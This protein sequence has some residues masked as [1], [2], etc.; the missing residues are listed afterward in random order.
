[1]SKGSNT[2]KFIIQEKAWNTMQQYAKI[3]HK[4]DGNEIS[5]LMPYKMIK[6]PVSDENVYE[7]FDPVILK[8]E[9]TGATTE[10]DGEAIRDYQIKAGMKYG[11]D[12]KFCWWHSHHTM[13]AFWSGTD[14]NEINA[15]ENDSWSLALVV[16][17]FQEYKLNVSVWHPVK[18]SE[19][20]R[21]E[22]IRSMPKETKKQLKEYEELCSNKTSIASS[23]P[24]WQKVGYG[25]QTSM[26]KKYTPQTDDLLKG[27]EL[28]WVDG[29]SIVP[30]AELIECV[31]EAV[32]TMIE[33]FCEGKIDYDQYSKT[34]DT[35]NE[36]LKKKNAKISIIKL[37]KGSVLEKSMTMQTWEHIKYQTDK[38]E[39]IYDSARV[40]Q[41]NS[42][43][44]VG[45]EWLC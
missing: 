29:E 32:E 44:G 15:W 4:E 23:M 13:D 27:T 16:N 17:L 37:T 12:I 28:K 35:M 34:I 40:T 25:S 30:Y 7:L 1:M 8:Q 45:G 36:Q 5:G 6:H 43:Y 22:I 33:E 24:G 14:K 38:I 26:W 3:A 39:K 19:D 31:D 21:L 10:L 41:Y 42:S 11:T 18:Y 9:N 2:P 20:V